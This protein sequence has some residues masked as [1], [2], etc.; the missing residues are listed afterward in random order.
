MTGAQARRP[1]PVHPKA[2]RLYRLP[3]SPLGPRLLGA[4]HLAPRT[5]QWWPT[6]HGQP[7]EPATA[8]PPCPRAGR[9]RRGAVPGHARSASEDQ[10]G[11]GRWPRGNLRPLFRPGPPSTFCYCSTGFAA[12]SCAHGRKVPCRACSNVGSSGTCS[13]VLAKES[14]CFLTRLISSVTVIRSVY[15]T[16]LS[17]KND[18]D[19]HYLDV[20]PRRDGRN[21]ETAGLLGDLG[22]KLWA[23][24]R[25]RWG[26]P[27]RHCRAKEPGTR[28]ENGRPLS[29]RSCSDGF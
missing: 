24:T 10:L 25:R 21:A 19:E 27:P 23:F 18:H 4:A 26:K 7:G 6:S 13:R 1:R 2:S 11:K 20:L 3:R 28:L 8:A 5:P 12:R 16:T 29:G 14:S 15:G 17:S 22:R 9:P